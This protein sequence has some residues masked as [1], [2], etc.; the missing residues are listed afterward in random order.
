MYYSVYMYNTLLPC[1]NSSFNTQQCV[2]VNE[3]TIIHKKNHVAVLKCGLC[4]VKKMVAQQQALPNQIR[5]Q[6]C[7]TF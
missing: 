5:V 1:H 3:V 2:G 4:V 7:P 6:L